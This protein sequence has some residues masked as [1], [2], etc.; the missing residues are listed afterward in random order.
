MNDGHP[1]PRTPRAR[2]HRLL[3][4]T[5]VMGDDSDSDEILMSEDATNWRS[6]GK[7]VNPLAEIAKITKGRAPRPG[8]GS[9]SSGTPPTPPPLPARSP[10]R[11]HPRRGGVGGARADPPR[12]AASVAA[13]NF[14][15]DDDDDEVEVT[16]ASAFRGALNDYPHARH[17]CQSLPLDKDPHRASCPMCYCFCR[18]P[19]DEWGDGAAPDADHC[20]AVDHP[21][22]GQRQ[23]RAPPREER[24]ERRA[25]RGRRQHTRLLRQRALNADADVV[26]STLSF[27]NPSARRTSRRRRRTSTRSSRVSRTRRRRRG[28]IR[29]QARSAAISAR[30]GGARRA[31]GGSSPTIRGWERRCRAGAHHERPAAGDGRQRERRRGHVIRNRRD[32]GGDASPAVALPTAAADERRTKSPPLV[33]LSGVQAPAQ[34]TQKVATRGFGDSDE[35]DTRTRGGGGSAGGRADA[36]V[37]ATRRDPRGRGS[38]R[39]RTDAWARADA[40]AHRARRSWLQVEGRGGR[41][42]GLAVR[43]RGGTRR[44]DAPGAHHLRHRHRGVYQGWRIAGRPVQ[45]RVVARHPRRGAHHP[46]QAHDGQRR[47]VRA[48]GVEALVPLGYASDERRRTYFAVRCAFH[49]SRPSASRRRVEARVGALA[50]L[51]IALAAVCLRRVKSQQIETDVPGK[52]EPIVDLPPRTIAIREIV[53]RRRRTFTGR[54]G[55]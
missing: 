2:L 39:A 41:E 10:P 53:T 42:D 36:G 19:C 28:E 46:Q 1:R 51:R 38:T 43:G 22:L 30:R 35:E 3:P 9:P 4:V 31:L 45:R 21:A 7:S 25:R 18:A 37:T 50:S 15:V 55:R 13:Q 11:R 5:V 14:G 23:G 34:G 12:P 40:H 29:P 17:L 44:A 27:P 32:L 49:I 48:A 33:R 16:G 24:R 47:D 6:V 54:E 26:S 20:R 8:T 52:F